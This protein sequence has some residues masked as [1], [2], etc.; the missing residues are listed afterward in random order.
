MPST[1]TNSRSRAFIHRRK[2]AGLDAIQMLQGALEELAQEASRK[3]TAFT[4]NGAARVAW[5]Q[6]K[7]AEIAQVMEIVDSPHSI[8]IGEAV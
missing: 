3:D 4:S 2:E 1:H 8:L 5:M 6:E 7:L